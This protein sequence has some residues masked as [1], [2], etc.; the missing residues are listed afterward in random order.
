MSIMARIA[1]QIE[2]PLGIRPK[3]V[4]GGQGLA[5]RCFVLVAVVDA[6]SGVGLKRRDAVEVAA[7]LL[8]GG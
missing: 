6:L 1:D 3:L 2:L 5:P 7:S 8:V 4:V